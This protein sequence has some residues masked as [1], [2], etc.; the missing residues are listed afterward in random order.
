MRLAVRAQI[1]P[2]RACVRGHLGDVG[3]EQVQLE[4]QTGRGQVGLGQPVQA[5]ARSGALVNLC[6]RVTGAGFGDDDLRRNGGGS[7]AQSGAQEFAT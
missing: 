4:Q 5:A 6:V 7:Q 2:G 3:F 1:E